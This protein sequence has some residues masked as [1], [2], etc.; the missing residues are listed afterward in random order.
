MSES[1]CMRFVTC[2]SETR[3]RASGG[4]SSDGAR[5]LIV[6]AAWGCGAVMMSLCGEGLRLAPRGAAIL[7]VAACCD[8][9]KARGQP[10]SLHCRAGRVSSH[11]AASMVQLCCS[12]AAA[13]AG[14]PQ[15]PVLAI[16]RRE[17][18]YHGQTSAFISKKGEKPVPR[19]VINLEQSFL[20]PFLRLEALA[21]Y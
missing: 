1:H 7:V 18:C 13:Q 21:F 10:A 20:R 6:M 14:Q 8:Q 11:R 4:A 15:T 2:A 5:G 16:P 9:A 12:H 3:F 17:L 19:P